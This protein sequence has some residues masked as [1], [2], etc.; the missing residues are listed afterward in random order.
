ME[1]KQR[2]AYDAAFKLKTINLRWD[3]ESD[4]EETEVSDKVLRRFNSDTEEDDFH[5]FSAQE[6]GEE[7]RSMTFPGRLL[8][9]FTSHVTGNVRKKKHLRTNVFVRYR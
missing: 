9:F 6:E 3:C 2:N 4:N 1:N 7:K 5:G 8:S